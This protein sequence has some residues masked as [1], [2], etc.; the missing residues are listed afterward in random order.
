M[1]DVTAAHLEEDPEPAY[2]LL[3]RIVP[4]GDDVGDSAGDG[5]ADFGLDLGPHFRVGRSFGTA[6]RPMLDFFRAPRDE[7]DAIAYLTETQ[8]SAESLVDLVRLGLVLRVE[9]TGVSDILRSLRGLA[10][11]PIGVVA[12]RE[13]GQ[14]RVPVLR[15]DGG[16]PVLRIGMAT[17]ILLLSGRDILDL[18]PDIAARAGVHPGALARDVLADIDA[19]LAQRLAVFHIVDVAAVGFGRAAKRVK[20]AVKQ[21]GR[22]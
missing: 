15:E 12:E 1:T 3:G 10:L 13:G 19:L 5:F 9:R 17:G 4:E 6:M 2:V 22:G 14:D 20:R 7:G 21:S 18:L 11:A 8:G 16:A